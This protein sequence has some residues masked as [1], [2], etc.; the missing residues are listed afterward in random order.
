MALRNLPSLGTL[1]LS[2]NKIG[3]V[4]LD[5]VINYLPKLKFVDLSNNPI[6]TF[7]Q[8]ELGWPQVT[9]VLIYGAMYHCDCDIYWLIVKIN[10]LQACSGPWVTCCSA[11]SACFLVANEGRASLYCTTPNRQGI[12]NAFFRDV[13]SEL[14]E[15]EPTTENPKPTTLKTLTTDKPRTQAQDFENNVPLSIGHRRRLEAKEKK[16]DGSTTTPTG[17][18]QTSTG[19]VTPYSIRIRGGEGSQVS[20]IPHIVITM[21]TALLTVAFIAY[22]VRLEHKHKLCRKLCMEEDNVADNHLV[23]AQQNA[24]SSRHNTSSEGSNNE[25]QAVH[26]STFSGGL[27]HEHTAVYHSTSSEPGLNNEQPTVQDGKS[28]D[29]FNYEQP[30]VHHSMS[31]GGSE[32]QPAVHHSIS[33]GGSEEQ[34]AV[35]HSISSGGSEEQPAVHHSMS[36]VGSEEQ[37]AVH[38][39]T[40]S[41]GSE[42]QPA[43]PN[44]TSSEPGLNYE[45]PTVH[46]STSPGRLNTEE[47]TV[48]RSTSSGRSEEQ[49]AEP[50][51]NYEQP[52]FS[53]NTYPGGLGYKK[54]AVYRRKSSG[55]VNHE[56]LSIHHYTPLTNPNQEQPT[57]KEIIQPEVKALYDSTSTNHELMPSTL[58]TGG[59]QRENM[60]GYL[61]VEPF[62]KS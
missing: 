20:N 28:S 59:R 12:Q 44:S 54:P 4:K 46:P 34:P 9:K 52:T 14:T 55:G 15:C 36:S 48:H 40:S 60:D 61:A 62:K 37:P 1:F 23:I 53:H 26:Y 47:P 18:T 11:C 3:Y 25:Q 7:T 50:R 58:Y 29:G 56:K 41:E 10:C 42:E 38:H 49:P 2:Y 39:S 57:I 17:T 30:A 43:V 24:N 33:S 19:D 13:A 45:Q 27:A 5:S 35:H 6:R 31:S 16:T 21:V 22:L 8:Y 51:L 32:E